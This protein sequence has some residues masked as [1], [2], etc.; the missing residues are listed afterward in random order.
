MEAISENIN[1]T[2]VL[3][4]LSNR[5]KRIYSSQEDFFAAGHTRSYAFRKT[6]LLKL[7][8]G[9]KSL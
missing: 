5:I 2:S 3:H 6:Q 7:K 1:E 9:D 4:N 8:T